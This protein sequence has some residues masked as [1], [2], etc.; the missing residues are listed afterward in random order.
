VARIVNRVG[1]GDSWKLDVTRLN[2]EDKVVETGVREN[3]TVTCE[4][5]DGQT[6][7]ETHQVFV[8]RGQRVALDMTCGQTT[9]TPPKKDKKPKPPKR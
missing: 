2:I 3:W 7:Y 9:T 4:S 1:R 8:E 5:P 6:V